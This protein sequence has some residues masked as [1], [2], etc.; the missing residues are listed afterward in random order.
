MFA[1]LAAK[2]A[3]VRARGRRAVHGRIVA[4]LTALTC[5]SACIPI[6]A[7]LAGM[8]PADP[9]AKVAAVGYRSTVAP[10]TSLRP[11]TPTSWRERSNGDV[12]PPKTDR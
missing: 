5:L 8:D 12:A 6:T 11:V 2:R 4:A 9:T 7:P 10:Y 1:P 3:A